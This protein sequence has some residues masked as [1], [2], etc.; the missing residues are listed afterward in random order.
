MAWAKARKRGK[1][2]FGEDIKAV[3]PLPGQLCNRG[4]KQYKREKHKKSKAVNQAGRQGFH[5]D[6]HLWDRSCS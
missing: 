1:S 6:L 2:G 3:E 5:G 4:G